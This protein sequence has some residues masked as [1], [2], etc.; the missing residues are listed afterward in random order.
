MHYSVGSV[1]GTLLL[2]IGYWQRG[3]RGFW[4][5]SLEVEQDSLLTPWLVFCW[6]R[7]VILALRRAHGSLSRFYDLTFISSLKIRNPWQELRGYCSGL[8]MEP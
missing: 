4:G 2:G 7:M 5:A 6:L 1:V 8:W 3:K